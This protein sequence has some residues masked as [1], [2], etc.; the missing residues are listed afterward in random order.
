M[1]AD[2]W[3]SG[4]IKNLPK[5][6]QRFSISSNYYT[7]I[8]YADTIPATLLKSSFNYIKYLKLVD[9]YLNERR[10]LLYI[11]SVLKSAPCLVELVVESFNLLCITQVPD[12]SEELEC[13][14]CWHVA[15]IDFRR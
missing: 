2:G 10:E 6:M 1:A 3:V 15:F 14:R 11:V 9:V 4:L 12:R 5:N 7:K 13:S 8:L